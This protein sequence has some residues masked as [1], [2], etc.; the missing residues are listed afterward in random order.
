MGNKSAGLTF[1][2]IGH[3]DSWGK[4]TQFV[5]MIRQEEANPALLEDKVKE[6]YTYIPPQK[7]FDVEINSPVTDAVNGF[8]IE[9]FISP[10]ELGPSHLWQNVKK[11]KAACQKAVQMGAD[12]VALGG[13]T[14]IILESGAANISYLDKTA[15]TTGNT[16][17]TAFIT[18][19][20]EKAVRV[21]NKRLGELTLLIIGSTG[22]IGSACAAYFSGKAKQ[23]LLTARQPGPLKKQEV[24]LVQAGISCSSS[25]DTQSLL[26]LADIVI[27]VASSLLPGTYLDLLRDDA[28][29]CDAG[30]PK[31]LQVPVNLKNQFF[32]SGGMG[33][34]SEGYS[35]VQD[36]YRR[37][38]YDFPLPNISHGCLLEAIVLALAGNATSYSSGKGNITTN[39]MHQMLEL[40][41]KHA[42]F[43]APFYNSNGVL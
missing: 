10:D 20:V 31:N 35:I 6:V 43:T 2:A 7:L 36:E 42:V 38:F 4:I 21:R 28:I 19:G 9:T 37:I 41:G 17:T 5:N 12:V 29:V 22:D 39:S 34:V 1:A 24:E 32:F 27:C 18:D 11:V 16:L 40:A 8:Y 23:M 15:F 30:Y 25:T 26:P 14:S 13:F 33:R 3:Q